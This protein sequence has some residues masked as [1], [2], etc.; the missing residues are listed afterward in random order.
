MKVTNRNGIGIGIVILT[1]LFGLLF[2]NQLPE[3]VVVQ[4]GSLGEPN[5]RLA[6]PIALIALPLL[7]LVVIGGFAIIPRID[8]LGE[9]IHD[10]QQAYDLLMVIIVGFIGYIHALLI[11]W[12]SGYEFAIIQ[13]LIP[14]IAILYYLAGHV[15]TKAK[16]N[17]FIGLRTPWTLTNDQVWSDTH[18]LGGR[19]MKIASIVTLG[20]LLFPRYAVGFIAIPAAGIAIFATVY[21]YWDYRRVINQNA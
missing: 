5:D 21:S 9:N 14:G 19:L 17:W 11:L 7:Q 10:F 3:Q 13:V 1:T 2:I 18:S 8:P 6:K 20:G 15:V 4:F 12:N 16:Q